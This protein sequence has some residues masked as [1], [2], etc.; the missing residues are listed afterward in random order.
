MD[1][2]LS[3]TSLAG[4][5]VFGALDHALRRREKDL[6]L[7]GEEDTAADELHFLLAGAATACLLLV[8]LVLLGVDA[9]AWGV[10]E[11]DAL[12]RPPPPKVRADGW[13]DE[14]EAADG[15]GGD[16]DDDDDTVV[17]ENDD[18]ADGE[19][20]DGR[21]DPFAGER[22]ANDPFARPAAPLLARVVRGL[23][24]HVGD[25]LRATWRC[26]AGF[27]CARL[28]ECSTPASAS[29]SC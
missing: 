4:E 8:G 29:A 3:G 16:D 10:L 20:V 19:G 24:R 28:R 25:C 7:S 12:G 11:D 14:D 1:A 9:D 27:V 5:E 6:S 13:L 2:L 23:V 26:T 21:D 17:W 15:G 18:E 22:D